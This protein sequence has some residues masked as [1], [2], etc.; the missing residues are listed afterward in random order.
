MSR[1]TQAQ[2]NYCLKAQDMV[3]DS[4]GNEVIPIGWMTTVYCFNFVTAGEDEPTTTG[5]I[6]F[7]ST[8]CREKWEAANMRRKG[9]TE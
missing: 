6:D 7:C 1:N 2:C 9:K 3:Y 5:E 8:E 4:E